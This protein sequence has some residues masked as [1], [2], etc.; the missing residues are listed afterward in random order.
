MDFDAVITGDRR[1]VARFGEWP[2]DLHDAHSDA[3]AKP[4]IELRVR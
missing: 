1:V 3:S 2:K 4:T